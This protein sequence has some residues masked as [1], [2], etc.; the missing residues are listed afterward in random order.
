MYTRAHM[1]LP[2][3]N[4]LARKIIENTVYIINSTE[5]FNK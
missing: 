5:I 1:C 2:K 3:Y 4:C